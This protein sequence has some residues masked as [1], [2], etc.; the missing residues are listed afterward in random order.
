MN[1]YLPLIGSVPDG[2]MDLPAAA[3]LWK[4]AYAADRSTADDAYDEE[5]ADD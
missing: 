3:G 4:S 1:T 5:T 2:A